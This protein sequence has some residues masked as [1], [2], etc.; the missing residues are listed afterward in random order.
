[1]ATPDSSQSLIIEH[2]GAPASG[3][4]YQMAQIPI[5]GSMTEF[6]TVEA[7]LFTGY[8]EQIPGEAIVI[9]RVET[10]RG[11]RVAQVVDSDNNGNPND[12]GA[13][14]LPGETFTDTA[15]GVSISVEAMHPTG[16]AVTISSGAADL[17]D[18]VEITVPNP[19]VNM[20]LGGS[21]P[22]TDTAKNRGTASSGAFVIRYYLSL[23]A[24]KDGG[25]ALL[26]GSR[27][28]PS[29]APAAQSTG[30][31]TLTI[32]S[33]TPLK[34]YYLLA[35]ADDTEIVGESE[36][37]NNC[38]ASASQV[39][40]EAPDLVEAAVS[41]P[42]ATVKRGGKFSV[43][44]TAKNTGI[45]KAKASV[46]R[47]YLSLNAVK[48]GGDALLTGSRAV[49][50]LDPAAQSRGTVT[51]SIPSTTPLKAYYLLTCADDTAIV[52]E[53][54]EGNNCKAAATKVTIKP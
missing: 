1:V 54:K 27:A 25:D 12:A 39:S 49:P 47:Y 19:P 23:D 16:F 9:H 34:A 21:F 28:V 7:R 24:V 22:V 48:D 14:W 37:G 40:I 30:T 36:E 38:K 41:K 17:P 53:G 18:L 20:R 2:L 5:G 13:M 26:T 11:D 52:E 4:N 45:A 50:S 6:Y 3:S 10:L 42:P 33:A 15:N 31:V 35:C 29:L 46:T 32:P 51:L 44:D 8:D 43:T